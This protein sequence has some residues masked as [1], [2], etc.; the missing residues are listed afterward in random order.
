M[1]LN[2][3]IWA[4][5]GPSPMN[6]GGGGDN[7]L[8]TAIAVNPNNTNVIYLGTAQGGV[9]RSRDAGNNWTPLFDHEPVLGI[10]EPAGIAID[11]SNTDTIYVGSSNRVGSAEPDTIGQAARGLFKSTDGGA[12][13][14][15]LGSG[16]PAGNTGTASQ[17]ANRTIN[18]V[19]VDPANSNVLYL[20]ATNGVFTSSDG[21]QNWTAAIGIS[22][23]TRSLVLDLSTPANARV[24]FAGVSG[25]GVFRSTNG[26]RNFTQVLGAATPAVSGVLSGGS[27]NRVVVAL[28]PPTSPANVN[29]VQVVYV[30]M[31]GRGSAPDPVGVF[32]SINQGNTWTS[33][34]AAGVSGTTYGGYALNMAV[35]PASP[36]NGT[37]DILYFG[38]QFQYTSNNSGVFFTAHSAGHADTHTYTLVPPTGGGGTT[39]YCGTDG[40]FSFST[41]TGVTW[42]RRNGGGLQ[43][44]LFYNIA[45]KPDPTAG[46]TAGALQDN[47]IQTTAGATSP[48][49]GATFGGDGWDVAY[50]RSSPPL[51]YTTSGGPATTVNFSN[52]DGQNFQPPITPPWTPADSGGFLLTQIA[53]EPSAS[54][55]IYVSGLQNLWQRLGGTWRIIAALGTSGNIDVAPTN[56]NNVV[57]AA[58]NQVFVTTNAL[59]A[60]VGPPTGV[61]FTNI[62]IN[63]PNRNVIRAVFDPIDPTVIYA[64]LTGFANTGLPGGPAQNVFKTT[65]AATSWTNISPPVDVP[66]G[67]IAVDGTTTPTTLYVGTDFGVIRSM[68]GGASWSVL[69]DIHFPRAPVFDLGFNPTASV[70]RAATYGR[71]V[72]EFKTPTGPAIA[73]GLQNQLDFGSICS[74]PSYLTITVYNVGAAN[75]IVFNVQVLVGSSDF[76]VLPTPPTPLTIDPGEEVTFTV[77]F[78]PSV[79]AGNETA[80]IRITS[81]DP[82]APVVDVSATGS[83]GVGRLVTA[84]ADAGDFGQVC[85]GLFV[86]ELL[87]L[88]NSGQCPLTV[89]AVQSNTAD[90]LAPSILNFPMVIAPGTSTTVPIRF[91]PTSVGF[92]GGSI[93]ITS[94]D[95]ASPRTVPVSGVAPAPRLALAIAN[96]GNFGRC[97]IGSFVDE[98]LTLANTGNCTLSVTAITSSAG[99]FL[100]PEV[101][102]LPLTIEAGNA[103]SLPLRFEPTALGPANATITVTSND[104]ASPK[105][106]AVNGDAPS[107]RLAVSGSTMFGGVKCCRREERRVAICNV[108]DCPLE[109][110][111]VYLRRRHRHYRLLL[112]PFPASLHPGACLDVVIQYHAVA[113]EPRSSELVIESDDPTCPERCIEVVAWTIWECCEEGRCKCREERREPCCKCDKRCRRRHDEDDEDEHD[114]EHRRGR[115]DPEYHD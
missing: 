48:A 87:V 79:P 60:T 71:G 9:W 111:R 91:Q 36:G 3:S 88:N 14:I 82:T 22:S 51:L 12:S 57:I 85:L 70:L 65:I 49:W 58:G 6:E 75:L 18:V 64:V 81:N 97:C 55:T 54:G 112:N 35:D 43:T 40:G 72:F 78:N 28:A 42:T 15:L 99:S 11:P 113:H 93:R 80:I 84:I 7:G 73:V 59:A 83:K 56:S 52:D 95:P 67:A 17:F 21:G 29:G 47:E 53:A 101:F 24:L 107:G 33:Q 98:P 100:V 19:I 38:C 4:P 94:D 92:H 44:G 34:G 46:A 41:D 25:S 26:G 109:V 39:V 115:E 106:I 32:L 105:S 20:A 108:G 61:V 23:D 8:V 77:K 66:C 31:S 30:T 89:F 114:D 5:I 16:F 45:V 103:L 68:D 76:T 27:F 1:T 110:R 63:L 50:D 90:F 13:W 62:T 96:S 104:P 102:S 86:D 69:D 74:G 37:T 10:G 2:G